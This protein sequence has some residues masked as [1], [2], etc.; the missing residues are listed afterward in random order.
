MRNEK[1][2]KMSGRES[3]S[4]RTVYVYIYINAELRIA[5][6]KEDDE[7]RKG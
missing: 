7:E 6:E 3:K 5:S 1:K 4:Y 2:Q